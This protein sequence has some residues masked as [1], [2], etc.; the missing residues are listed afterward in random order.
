MTDGLFDIHYVGKG[1]GGGSAGVMSYEVGELI[2]S[3]TDNDLDQLISEETNGDDDVLKLKLLAEIMKR[4][5]ALLDKVM[6]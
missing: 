6:E 4:Q 3:L 1:R 2:Y 5:V